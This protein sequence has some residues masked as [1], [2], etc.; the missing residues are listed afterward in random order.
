M[1][2]LDGAGS[3][4]GEEWRRCTCCRVGRSEL[5]AWLGKPALILC[6]PM[7]SVLL[8]SFFF[9]SGLGLGAACERETTCSEM[10]GLL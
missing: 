3:W 10:F 9:P 8:P 5:P 7:D 6:L 1:G 4:K 2:V